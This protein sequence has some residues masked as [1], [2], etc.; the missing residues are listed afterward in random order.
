MLRGATIVLAAALAAP[1]ALAAYT[2]TPAELNL[3]MKNELQRELSRQAKGLV[4]GKVTCTIAASKRTA[5]C[6]AA[7]TARAAGKKGV[8][9]LAVKLGVPVTWT[10]TGVRCTSI[11]T[12]RRVAC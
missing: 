12:G 1:A 3:A 7:F 10:T 8:Y 5:T 2:P 6:K 11:K 9:G 4:V